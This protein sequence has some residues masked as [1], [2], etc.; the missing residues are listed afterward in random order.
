MDMDVEEFMSAAEQFSS[1]PEEAQAYFSD[2]RKSRRGLEVAYAA[3]TEGL[4]TSHSLTVFHAFNTASFLL[5]GRWE[6]ACGETVQGA[7]WTELSLSLATA[8]PPL[9]PSA[10]SQILST[11]AV[12]AKTGWLSWSPDTR[13][14]LLARL[15]ASARKDAVPSHVPLEALA[16]IVTSFSLAHAPVST[17]PLEVHIGVAAAFQETSLSPLMAAALETLGPVLGTLGTCDR[18]GLR[19]VTRL[20]MLVAAILE[21]DFPLVSHVR[22][23]GSLGRVRPGA[24]ETLSIPPGWW[25]E[26]LGPSAIASVFELYVEAVGVGG[27]ESA[28][29]R[30]TR[31]L[32]A[33]LCCFDGVKMARAGG[34]ERAFAGEM[35][36]G[37]AQSL[38]SLL[39]SSQE[40][41]PS[42]AATLALTGAVQSLMLHGTW[43]LWVGEDGSLE[44]PAQGGD[45][46]H[47]LNGILAL[48][49]SL[50]EGAVREE[51]EESWLFEAYDNL[52]VGWVHMATAATLASG[53]YAKAAPY[54]VGVGRVLF[55]G[56]LSFLLS[57][58]EALEAVEAGE[59]LAMDR[60]EDQ[61]RGIGILARFPLEST[62]QTLGEC[63]S[64]ALGSLASVPRASEALRWGVHLLTFV[65][66][67]VPES[68]SSTRYHIGSLRR[69]GVE[70][71]PG[72]GSGGGGASEVALIP[73]A[74]LITSSGYDDGESEELAEEDPVYGIMAAVLGLTADAEALARIPPAGLS[75]LLAFLSSWSQAYLL[76]DTLE[77]ETF[78]EHLKVALSSPGLADSVLGALHA[79]FRL[80]GG[81]WVS[82]EYAVALAV[83]TAKTGSSLLGLRSVSNLAPG[84][85]QFPQLWDAYLT[86]SGSRIWSADSGQG[87]DR[88]LFAFHSHAVRGFGSALAGGDPDFRQTLFE[89]VS[90]G[91]EPRLQEGHSLWKSDMVRDDAAVQHLVTTLG[92]LAGVM[93]CG[94]REEADALLG[95]LT[96]DASDTLLSTFSAVLDTFS[97]VEEEEG[98]VVARVEDLSKCVMYV[99]LNG[100]DRLLPYASDDVTGGFCERVFSM[101]QI[102]SGHCRGG[103][104]GHQGVAE[105][106]AGAFALVESV[107]RKDVFGEMAGVVGEFVLAS[108][109]ELLCVVESEHVL[110]PEV[111]RRVFAVLE[112]ATREWPG[113][114]VGLPTEVYETFDRVA[115]FGFYETHDADIA[116]AALESLSHVFYYHGSQVSKGEDG[117]GAQLE[118]Q[119]DL[120]R[121][122]LVA[123]LQ[124]CLLDEFDMD[125]LQPASGMM[126]A[127]VC[128]IG[129]TFEELAGDLVAGV[130]DR[131]RERL[132]AALEE[133]GGAVEF[134][135]GR[136]ERRGFGV[137]FRRFVV[138]VRPFLATR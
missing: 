47:V 117:M 92:T 82:Q 99:Y 111:G 128:T 4:S 27:D 94:V 2:L 125:L 85:S 91:V 66:A 72:K 59:V 137:A 71:A 48:T 39:G 25:E 56:Y 123:L 107:G 1:R 81:G 43:E 90:C 93:G 65:L 57:S 106:L 95:M 129:E 80:V 46:E 70:W 88:V 42:P 124:A 18:E 78:P 55:E 75:A 41:G 20:V 5:P 89:H 10:R 87:S 35:M 11:L 19:G 62:L 51:L 38:L 23:L 116:K 17:L 126:F 32:I 53:A 36:N 22:S 98:E 83:E 79:L 16:G 76:P 37:L 12:C 133:L 73:E 15:L 108:V 8:M 58:S 33:R 97:R 60:V 131:D 136:G 68:F 13:S 120:L 102:I 112:Q 127:L 130:E 104:G 29:A 109:G 69:E 14:S 103:K 64:T 105:V 28:L 100:A 3:A 45:E 114:V 101:I 121:S 132:V 67:D 30:H 138:E 54:L 113:L 135:F 84:L 26:C 44:V 40:G 96:G 34:E 52:H 31:A 50:L 6:D 21:W 77:Y 74:V 134:V 119:P 9:S 24:A 63:I 49:E 7:A 61:L 86:L 110:I 115:R 122:H 118:A